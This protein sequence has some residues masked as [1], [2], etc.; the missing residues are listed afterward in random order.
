MF[1][2]KTAVV[3]PANFQMLFCDAVVLLLVFGNLFLALTGT[4]PLFLLSKQT[5][6]FVSPQQGHLS[7]ELAIYKEVSSSVIS[8]VSYPKR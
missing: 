6:L 3:L 4:S 1:D 5:P 7:D 2:A 8:V